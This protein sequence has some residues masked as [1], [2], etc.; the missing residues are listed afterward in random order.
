MNNP[1]EKTEGFDGKVKLY[2]D[3]LL[4]HFK[5][6]QNDAFIEC[7]TFLGN[8]LQ[9]ALDAGFKKCYSIEIQPHLYEKAVSR[10]SKEI[11][12]NK[13]NLFL[14]SSETVL[15]EII[16]R[17]DCSATFWLDAHI[18][19]NY[20]DKIGKNC[21]IFE[22]L[23]SISKSQI[24]NHTLLIDDLNCFGKEA[25][26]FITIDQVKDEILKI[27]KNYKFEFLDAAKSKNIL[28][29]YV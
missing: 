19:S 29:A 18:S 13:V 11:N 14:G 2:Y 4:N 21:P 17:L 10:F 16:N 26:D 3:N 24:K 22:E 8:G 9:C 1:W 7:G 6:F 15:E 5:R 28:V 27:N 12:S 25:H 23:N 20:G